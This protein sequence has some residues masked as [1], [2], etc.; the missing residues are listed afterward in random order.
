M[1]AIPLG[2]IILC[3]IIITLFLW[4]NTYEGVLASLIQGFHLQEKATVLRETYIPPHRFLRM[5][6]LLSKTGIKQNHGYHA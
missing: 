2:S 4:L 3:L 1:L 6:L 5:A